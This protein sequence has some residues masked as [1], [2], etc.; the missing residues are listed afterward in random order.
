MKYTYYGQSCFAVQIKGKNILF[1]PFITGNPLAKDIDVNKIKAD[2]IL[3]SHGHQD[4][5]LDLVSIAKR[6]GAIVVSNFEIIGWLAKQGILNGH[7]FNHGGKW[8]FDFGTVK[9]VNAIH[10]SSYANGNYA[11]NP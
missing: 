1:D 7:P 5:T 10:S 9:Y 11:G 4:H 2:Y 3:V 6:T 8:K